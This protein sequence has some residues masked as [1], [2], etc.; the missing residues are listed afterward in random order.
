MEHVF[1]VIFNYFEEI[2][3]K[4]D[5]AKK[6]RSRMHDVSHA[7]YAAHSDYF[8]TNDG[9]FASKALVAYTYLGVPTQVVYYLKFIGH[10]ELFE[11]TLN[12]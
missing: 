6:S 11:Q 5:A 4:P 10:P 2:R 12:S 9:N 3:Y 7:I 1:E 8:V